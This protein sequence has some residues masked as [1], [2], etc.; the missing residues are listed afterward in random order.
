MVDEYQDTNHAQY[1]LIN[2]LAAKRRNICV[3]GDDDQSIYKF[4]GANIEN[5]L[6][7]EKD[8][9]GAM[10]IRLEQN[11]RCTKKI[12]DAANEVIAHNAQREGQDP[13]DRKRRRRPR[14][15]STG[16]PTRAG[17]RCSSPT[18]F[19]RM[20][21]PAPDSPTTPSSTA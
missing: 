16:R 3:V 6:G 13:V 17:R 4:R 5:I 21:P 20:S 7:F 19:W 11:Y 14:C 15:G 12:L 1:R 2:L 10:V 9:P 18:P 8:F